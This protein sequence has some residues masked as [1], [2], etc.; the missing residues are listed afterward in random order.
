MLFSQE[1]GEL[2]QMQVQIKQ[3]LQYQ[4]CFDYT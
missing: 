3:T 2:S 1:T 4:V